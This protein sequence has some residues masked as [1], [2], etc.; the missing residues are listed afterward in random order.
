VPVT[1]NPPATLQLP[2][3]AVW[4]KNSAHMAYITRQQPVR[5]AIHASQMIP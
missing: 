4:R 3:G 5:I 2:P 1:P